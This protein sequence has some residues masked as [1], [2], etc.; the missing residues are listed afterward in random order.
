MTSKPWLGR[1]PLLVGVLWLTGCVTVPK[2]IQGH[3]PEQNLS[4]IQ[5]APNNFKGLEA[6]LGGKVLTVQ[7]RQPNTTRLEIAAQPLDRYGAPILDSLSNGRIFADVPNLLE[8]ADFKDR[9]VTVLGTIMG[10]VAG[11]MNGIPYAYILVNTSGFIRWERHTR[12][13]YGYIMPAVPAWYYNNNWPYN[14]GYPG[15]WPNPYVVMPTQVQQS[16]Y[17]APN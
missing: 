14:G 11:K 15:F 17:L 8:P 16:E 1:W 9:Y 2:S 5:L 4:Q 6:R 3:H 12:I 7:N 10:E 13:D